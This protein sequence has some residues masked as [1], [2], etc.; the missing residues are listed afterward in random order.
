LTARGNHTGIA[1]LFT[2]AEDGS[3]GRIPEREAGVLVPV[4]FLQNSLGFQPRK[5]DECL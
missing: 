3:G 4:F 1:E 5:S 2:I